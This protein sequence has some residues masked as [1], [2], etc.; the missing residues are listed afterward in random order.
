MLGLGFSSNTYFISVGEFCLVTF[1]SITLTLHL[2][3]FLILFPPPLPDSHL[4]CHKL[5]DLFKEDG[6]QSTID[7]ERP[8]SSRPALLQTPSFY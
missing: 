2:S 5:S 4:L 7:S 6:P 3:L 1:T 8:G